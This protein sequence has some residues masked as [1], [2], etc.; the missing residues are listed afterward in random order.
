MH[1]RAILIKEGLVMLKISRYVFLLLIVLLVSILMA[2]SSTSS[3]GPEGNTASA[4]VAIDVQTQPQARQ[5]SSS[6]GTFNNV[7]SITLDV[8]NGSIP[9]ITAQP[10]TYY[11]G[12][13]NG[14]LSNLPIGPPL[15]FVC[16]TYNASAV[17]IFTGT[18]V[19]AMTGHN[20]SVTIL[21]APVTNRVT[22]T[23]P[24]ITKI[25][26]PEQI[27]T[28]AA[29]KRKERLD[30]THGDCHERKPDDRPQ[31][32]ALHE[33][34]RDI[35][36]CERN[37]AA[38]AVNHDDADNEQRQNGKEKFSS[39]VTIG[40]CVEA[41]SGETLAYAVTAAPGGGSFNPSSGTITLNGTTGIIVLNYTAP[42]TAG[43]YTQS[44]TVTNNQSN[45]VQTNFTTVVSGTASPSVSV[46]FNPV[47]TA[48][49]A[50]RSGSDVT[51]TAVVRDA[52]PARHPN[53]SPD[54]ADDQGR[55]EPDRQHDNVCQTDERGGGD[56]ADGLQDMPDSVYPRAMT[57]SWKFSISGL[58]FVD[59]TKNPAVLQ[60]YNQTISGNLTLTVTNRVGGA[61]T[62][63]YYIA[64]GL[65]PDNVVVSGEQEQMG[66]AI[67]SENI[68]NLAAIVSTLAGSAANFYN[69]SSIT[70]DG[71]NLY[72]AD[73]YNCTIRKIVI[74]T[75]AVTTLAGS[76]GVYGSADGTGS[77][78]SFSAPRGITTDGTN[79]YVADTFSS[80]IRK[81]VISTG[82]VTTLA[83]TAG[84]YG[85][86]DGTG[87]AAN[88]NNPFGITT[89][90]TNLYVADTYNNTIRKIVISTGAVT[91]LAG[92]AGVYGS[93]DGTGSAA[94]FNTPFGI[95]TDGTNLYVADT[96]N[97]TIRKIQ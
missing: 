77:A 30:D 82:A 31:N 78:A 89:D 35:I 70:T 92:T 67:Q 52:G 46:Q 84:V 24:N 64:P 20:D 18:T 75:G 1:G 39:T 23:F 34:R 10:L 29:H 65:F 3:G 14:T 44:I 90:G 17:Q 13:Q 43:T 71:T 60:G 8:F 56:L 12:V 49:G 48:L 41:S 6:L 45:W 87:S 19:Q 7:T 73:T 36:G 32:L 11:N 62:I 4:T 86:A 55:R 27:L 42:S 61:T 21:L 85:S 5:L 79:L 2:C 54:S 76:E 15:T 94:N 16:H 40:I 63:S 58:T 68:L 81:I 83:G 95:T 26:V 38:R 97:N 28:S 51:F 57:Y 53:R 74:S 22:Q 80:T 59:N 91:T 88:F 9:I 69:P 72:V 25:L 50:E 33:E 66:G 47:V 93:A 96:Y 37:N